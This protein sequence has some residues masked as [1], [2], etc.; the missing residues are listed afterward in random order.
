MH[1][2]T[3]TVGVVSV[4][5]LAAGL[6]STPAAAASSSFTCT[7]T[8]MSPETIPAGAY[9][10]LRVPAGSFCLIAGGSV[11][12]LAPVTL[13]DAAGILVVG[14]SFTVSGPLTVGRD[15]ALGAPTN[16]TPVH[17][18]GPV[19]VEEN[20]AFLLGTETPYG[21]IFAAIDGPV[22][23]LDASTVQIHNTRVSGPV[24]ISGGGGDNA[25]VDAVSESFGYFGPNNFSDLEDNHILGP[26]T[27]SGY[28]GVWGGVLRNVIAGPL[29]FS[30]NSEAPAIDEYDIGS[31]LIEGPATCSG[32]DP[33]PNLGASAGYLSI[34]RGPV[35]GSQA[36]TCTGV[37]SGVSG[38]PV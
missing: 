38:P 6:G 18:Q 13:G 33:A 17:I 27:E 19:T 34:V 20:G 2:T 5:L 28:R 3:K 23:G 14:G 35:G 4:L 21:A 7:G 30:N 10:A 15:A 26:V 1:F 36:A 16:A 32:N 12:I 29:T 37:P 8:F 22:T 24:T 11:H 9:D 31:N 25:L